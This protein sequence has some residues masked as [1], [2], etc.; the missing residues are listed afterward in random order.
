M[1]GEKV[2]MAFTDP[3]WRGKVPPDWS[4]PL[5]ADGWAIRN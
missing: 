2:Q 1:D 4:G 5:G 3:P